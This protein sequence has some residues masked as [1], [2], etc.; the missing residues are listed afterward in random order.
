MNIT[1]FFAN[2]HFYTSILMCSYVTYIF[3]KLHRNF[4]V[5]SFIRSLFGKKLQCSYIVNFLVQITLKFS[6]KGYPPG[7]F[8][9]CWG[10]LFI[11][12]VTRSGAEM[13]ERSRELFTMLRCVIHHQC[14][15]ERSGAEMEER[16]R[17]WKKGPGNILQCWG[18]LFT[19]SVTRSGA[20]MEEKSRE[21]FTMLR[22]VIH[23]QCNAERRWMKGPGNIY[24]KM[25]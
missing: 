11:I 24:E 10:A 4:C 21:L 3:T 9:Q 12:S 1:L 5:K 23:H 15:A 13:E 6:F 22:C 19:I 8:L 7:N 18:A 25:L 2:L 20:E 14:N 16:S 17:W